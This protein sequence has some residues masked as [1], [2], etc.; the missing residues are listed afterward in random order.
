M[1]NVNGKTWRIIGILAGILFVVL[2]AVYAYGRRDERVDMLQ[3]TAI[4]ADTN[5]KAIIGIQKDIEYIKKG[6]D[7][8]KEQ[9]KD[10][11]R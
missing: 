10:A 11:R 7:D 2:G 1:G 4:K 5:E 3:K 9:L 8:I 6:V